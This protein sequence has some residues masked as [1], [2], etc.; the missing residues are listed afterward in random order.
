[1]LLEMTVDSV[2]ALT[3]TALIHRGLEISEPLK[4]RLLDIVRAWTT[5]MRTL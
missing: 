2:C 4:G 5:E 1:M 3:R